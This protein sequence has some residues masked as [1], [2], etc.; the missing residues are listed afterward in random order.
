M[1]D[2]KKATRDNDARRALDRDYTG[3]AKNARADAVENELDRQTH[4]LQRD[5]DSD[6]PKH[7]E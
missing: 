4:R 7:R 1:A 3:Q 2:D 6:S 5:H